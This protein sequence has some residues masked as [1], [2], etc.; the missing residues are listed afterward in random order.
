MKKRDWIIA[1]VILLM[2]AVVWLI[3]KPDHTQASALK[4]M[5]DGEI[6][7]I[8]P[9]DENREIPIGDHNICRIE[10]GIVSMIWADCPDKICVKTKPITQTGETIICLPNKVI[11][12]LISSEEK[13]NGPDSI[14]S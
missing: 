1:A 10:K 2:A 5:V 14:S 8:Y 3:A 11:L 4:I 7:G 12:E 6:M 13:K 9:L